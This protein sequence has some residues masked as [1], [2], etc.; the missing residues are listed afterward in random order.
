LGRASDLPRYRCK[1]C[2]RTFNALTK[3]PL[4]NLRMK[5]K[6]A[7]LTEALI[8]KVSTAKAARRCD[9]HYTTA[10]RWR[11]RF[12]AA[13]AGDKLKAL[14]GIVEGDVTLIPESF[15]GKR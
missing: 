10:F 13:L 12:L 4:E 5:D 9:V 15:E 3:T 8:E 14:A 7:A 1:A 11:Y 6:W 2:W